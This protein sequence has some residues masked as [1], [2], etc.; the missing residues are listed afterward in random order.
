MNHYKF[1]A[2]PFVTNVFSSAE[3]ETYGIFHITKKSIPIFHLLIH[4]GYPQE[5]PTPICTDNITSKGFVNRNMQ[6]KMS[7]TWDMQLHWL[8]DRQK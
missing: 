2:K 1:Y 4:T 6:M 3:A 7:K 8:H 5:Q